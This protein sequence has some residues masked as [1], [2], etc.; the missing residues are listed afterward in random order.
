MHS[1]LKSVYIDKLDS[2][3]NKYTNTYHSAIKMKPVNVKSNTCQ[4]NCWNIVRKRIAKNK[5]KIV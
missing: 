2:T 4:I 5:S 1:V 3:V